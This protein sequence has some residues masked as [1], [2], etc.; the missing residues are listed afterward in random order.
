MDWGSLPLAAPSND[1]II[2]HTTVEHDLMEWS[3]V[4]IALLIAISSVVHFYLYR[5][6]T[7]ALI[8]QVL[9]STCLLDAVHTLTASHFI[10]SELNTANYLTFS[11]TLSRIF[12]GCLWNVAVLASFILY[13]R[14]M[15]GSSSTQKPSLQ[16]DHRALLAVSFLFL[17]LT[18]A[19]I[20]ITTKSTLQ[21][22]NL[23]NEGVLTRPYEIIPLC[24]Y[25]LVLII[26]WNYYEIR[27]C[28]VKFA[29][30][31]SLL[32]AIAG[33]MHMTFGSVELFD[34]HFNLAHAF[35]LLS[36]LTLFIGLQVDFALH[37]VQ[38]AKRRHIVI[39]STTISQATIGHCQAATPAKHS[40]CWIYT[41]YYCF[42]YC[43]FDILP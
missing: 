39:I 29:L 31:L 22:T 43:R 9:L 8:G 26:V 38:P 27:P 35:K 4:A 30:L 24:L 17:V 40:C 14:A 13:R 5:D 16:Y 20:A 15:A 6:I 10:N 25:I 32:P 2:Q 1:A 23:L 18:A 12:N 42:D 28:A 21:P 3:G 11:W 41:E 34:H 7:I 33:E 19:V 36:Y 37:P